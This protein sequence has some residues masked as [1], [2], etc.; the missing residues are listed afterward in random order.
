M[1][2][3]ALIGH[4]LGVV[5]QHWDL[6]MRQSGAE[7]LKAICAADPVTLGSQALQQL[8]SNDIVSL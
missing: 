4:V 6:S 2:Q 7:S 5:L 8:V 1:Y 3:N